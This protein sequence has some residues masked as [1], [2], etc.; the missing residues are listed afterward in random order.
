MELKTISIILVFGFLFSL[1]SA[2]TFGYGRT[3]STPINYSLIPTVNN[4]E[5]FQSYTPTTLGSWL[6]STFGWVTNTVNDLVNYYTKT[7]SDNRFAPISEPLAFNG[8][9]AF[10]SDL[11]G[12]IIKLG[13][14]SI[15]SGTYYLENTSWGS[16]ALTNVVMYIKPSNEAN[17][18]NFSLCDDASCTTET[19]QWVNRYGNATGGIYSYASA[20]SNKF[21]YKYASATGLNIN[22]TGGKA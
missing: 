10:A 13:N 21:Y 2:E 7:E 20:D 16:S 4:S 6:E 18:F 22:I 14:L 1:V 19:K 3:E 12:G 5:Y 11:N 17:A 9:L 8:T 15:T